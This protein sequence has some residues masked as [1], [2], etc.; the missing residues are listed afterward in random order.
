MKNDKTDYDNWKEW[1]DKFYIN[2]TE[3]IKV[4]DPGVKVLEV[5]NDSD[6]FIID[7]YFDSKGEFIYLSNEGVCNEKVLL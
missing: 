3:C 7:I 4:F 5:F 1:L 2:Y 6:R